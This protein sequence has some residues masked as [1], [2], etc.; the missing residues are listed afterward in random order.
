MYVFT[1]WLNVINSVVGIYVLST[2]S[3]PVLNTF[4]HFHMSN[5]ILNNGV[6]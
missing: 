5:E 3:F 2:G 1:L 4:S 6:T